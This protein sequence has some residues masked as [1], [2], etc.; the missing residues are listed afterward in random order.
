MKRRE[1][2]YA[3]AIIVTLVIVL[4]LYLLFSYVLK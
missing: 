4:T 2:Y 1:Y 3:E